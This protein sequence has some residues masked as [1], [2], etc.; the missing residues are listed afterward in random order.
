MKDDYVSQKPLPLRRRR[1]KPRRGPQRVRKIFKRKAVAPWLTG[2]SGCSLFFV[3]GVGQLGL[4]IGNPGNKQ[5]DPVLGGLVDGNA[6]AR[7][8]VNRGRDPDHGY[9][10]LDGGPVRL[11]R[12]EIKAVT[13]IHLLVQV[14]Q[15]TRS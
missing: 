1:E 4:F 15:H 2:A 10:S 7:G 3:I 8:A 9:C 12:P 11:V 5:A 14:K 13:T 6:D